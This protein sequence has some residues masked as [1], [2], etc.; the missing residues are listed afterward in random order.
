MS[1][2]LDVNS[3]TL[4]VTTLRKDNIPNVIYETRISFSFIT[5]KV[6]QYGEQRLLTFY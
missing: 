3:N 1:R 2:V 4:A 6:Y 5:S